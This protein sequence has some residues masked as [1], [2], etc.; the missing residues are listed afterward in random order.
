MIQRIISFILILLR[1]F[2]S[3]FDFL[4]NRT[5]R[6]SQEDLLKEDQELARAIQCGDTKTVERIRNRRKYYKNI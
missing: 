1:N 2:G 4:N 6:I 3:M 5:K